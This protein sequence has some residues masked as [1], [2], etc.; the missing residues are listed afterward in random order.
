VT[1]Q[2]LVNLGNRREKHEIQGA[3]LETALGLDDPEVREAFLVHWY[4][5][6]AAGLEVMRGL[7]QA[8]LESTPFFMQA[9][10]QRVSVAREVIDEGSIFPPTQDSPSAEHAG[11]QIGPYQLLGKMGDGG[12]GVV[13]HARQ[14][15]PIQREVALKIIRLGMDT[16]AVIARFGLEQQALE[17]MDHRNIARV[18]D[19]GT[20][21]AGRPYFVMELVTGERITHYCDGQRLPLRPRLKLFLQVCNAIQHAHQKGV[22]H[23]DLK[24]SNILVSSLDG[25]AVPKVID[26]GIAKATGSDS[27]WRA[28]ITERDQIIGTPA[29]MS[30]EQVDLR[31]ID[32]DTRSDVYSLGVVLY[33]LL[34][35]RQPFDEAVLT[36]AGMAEMRRMLLED[37]PP[38]PSQRISSGDAAEVA[39]KRGLDG[40]SLRSQ[41]RGD[42]DA[43]VSKALAKD[44]NHRYQTVNSLA[45]DVQRFLNDEPV[46]ACRPGRLY[47]MGKFVRRH[48]AA[49]WSGAAVAAS[50]VAGLGTATMLYV[51]ERTALAEQ[52]RLATEA[53]R[54]RAEESRLRKQAQVLAS[55][56]QVAGLLNRGQL[57][58]RLPADHDFAGVA[59]LLT[60]GKA[61]EADAL[62][63]GIPLT[64]VK[65]SPDAA[66]VF[67]SL[68]HWNAM[69]GAWQQALRCFSW[70]DQANR[71]D[72]PESLIEGTDPMC[73]AAL[74]AEFGA[75]S[76]YQAFRRE[77]LERFLPVRGALAAE[78]LLKISLLQPLEAAELA[79][80]QQAAAMCASGARSDYSRRDSFPQWDALALTMFYH[81]QGD[82]KKVLEWSDRCLGFPGGRGDRERSV[83][84]LRAMAYHHLGDHRE[85]AISLAGAQAIVP[86][87]IAHADEMKLD[88][89]VDW[90]VSRI[91]LREAESL[92]N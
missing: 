55:I 39:A 75:S 7:L 82:P 74:L 29:Y 35:G 89:W 25:V 36:R 17:L 90:S 76:D 58:G 44:R 81:R 57:G 4:R 53:E 85:A 5:D 80:L 49:C 43:I 38:V 48:R 14:E 6:D 42:L 22:I 27:G 26:F 88:I 50:L 54:A 8:S 66:R 91:L 24:P 83:R 69:R 63:Q 13:Y 11:A 78:H 64:G 10:E 32:V 73:L 45:M 16:E 51:R 84:C 9:R 79:P 3:V 20:T 47:L 87:A 33:E 1:P 28:G 92:L 30:P 65:P 23:R 70:L 18:L 46:L 77:A 37:E 86:P 71:F 2:P 41:L 15:Q 59:A 68:G 40:V 56:S 21:A 67:R 72:H 60:E 19:A 31:G 62:L 52:Q 12:S 34:A 61:V